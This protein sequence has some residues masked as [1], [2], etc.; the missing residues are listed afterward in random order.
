MILSK[1]LFLDAVACLSASTYH[2]IFNSIYD[3]GLCFRYD[4]YLR[5]VHKYL[6]P[7]RLLMS[8]DGFKNAR[9]CKSLQSPILLLLRPTKARRLGTIIDHAFVHIFL[10][11]GSSGRSI[12]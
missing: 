10:A 3:I 7:Q 5:Y 4:I 6:F 8:N 9:L 1:T 12:L 2:V 11:F